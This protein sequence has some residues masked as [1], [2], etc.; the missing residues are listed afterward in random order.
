MRAH[1]GPGPGPGPGPRLGP[2]PGPG[3]GLG[4][5][6]GPGTGDLFVPETDLICPNEAEEKKCSTNENGRSQHNL[7]IHKLH[8]FF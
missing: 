8:V 2:G 1:C 3:L 6:S 4:P 7:T 5:G